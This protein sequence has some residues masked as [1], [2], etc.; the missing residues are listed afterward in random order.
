MNRLPPQNPTLWERLSGLFTGRGDHG[1]GF[2]FEES[3]GYMKTKRE[4]HKAYFESLAQNGFTVK[5]SSSADYLADIYHNGQIMAFYTKQDTLLKNPFLEVPDRLWDAINDRARSIALRCGICTEKPYDEAKAEKLKN[6]VYKLNEANGVVLTCKKHPLFD[7]V[8]STYRVD[9]E[10]E[11]QAIQRVYHYNKAAAY[12]DFAIRAGLVDEKKLF[13][14]TELKVIHAGLV[15]MM[16]VD[17]DLNEDDFNSVARL[18]DRIEEVLPELQKQEY[19]FDYSQEFDE[20]QDMD[21][22]EVGG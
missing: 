2:Q 11:N 10:N 17:N 15:K 5:K 4:F 22:L 7:Y 9:P 12:Q 21:E 16:T 13:S 6:G 1:D 19:S 18:I 3:E 14:E 20:A 8:L